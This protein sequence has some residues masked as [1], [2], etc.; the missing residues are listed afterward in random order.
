MRMKVLHAMAV[1]KA[2]VTTTRGAEGLGADGEAP[3]L[4]IGDNSDALAR[5]A[6]T[7][8]QHADAR[9]RLGAR[10]RA[11]VE[12]HHSP[13]AYVERLERVLAQATARRAGS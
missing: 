2:V 3:P 13:A 5:A 11:Y 4:E 6:V 1:G 7:L 10:A 8:L 12:K 9:C